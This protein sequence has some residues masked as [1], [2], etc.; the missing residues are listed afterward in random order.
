MNIHAELKFWPE[1]L[2]SGTTC[3]PIHE[4]ETHVLRFEYK[5]CVAVVGCGHTTGPGGRKEPWATVYRIGAAEL[6]SNNKHLRDLLKSLSASYKKH[7]YDFAVG[8]AET[9]WQKFNI[10]LAII[11]VREECSGVLVSRR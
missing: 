2:L 1:D 10:D 3:E 5:E 6:W 8:R 4:E 11:P 7:G 9:P